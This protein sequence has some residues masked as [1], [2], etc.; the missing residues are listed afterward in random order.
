MTITSIYSQ[1]EL[2]LRV[3]ESLLRGLS[4]TP[5]GKLLAEHK[6]RVLEANLDTIELLGRVS[7]HARK[8][9]TLE[10]YSN[11]NRTIFKAIQ[12]S[13]ACQT[14]GMTLEDLEKLGFRI[15]N[16][17]EV[18]VYGAVILANIGTT[19]K[20]LL[21]S[22]KTSHSSVV[23]V[24]H[25]LV[26]SLDRT[27]VSK[28]NYVFVN[29]KKKTIEKTERHIK[30]YEYYQKVGQEPC[31]TL[32]V[33]RRNIKNTAQLILDN[34][35]F[36][37]DRFAQHKHN[38]HEVSLKTHVD[39]KGHS[40]SVCY[41]FLDKSGYAIGIRRRELLGKAEQNKELKEFKKNHDF[42]YSDEMNKT[43]NDLK[44]RI[45]DDKGKLGYHIVS[46]PISNSKAF[47]SISVTM[48]YLAGIIEAYEELNSELDRLKEDYKRCD[49]W[50]M[51]ELIETPIQYI[52][53][54]LY[55]LEESLNRLL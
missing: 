16:F 3:L 11:L 18:D 26:N 40:V 13:R 4:N 29:N 47:L 51:S 28:A 54:K 14:H 30:D 20:T 37:C 10:D 33:L 34:G 22:I 12:L 44:L 15:E 39:K 43:M 53:E 48:D 24:L 1:K 41:G 46:N 19:F 36:T 55:L 21:N 27:P 42:L 6:S 23:L 9:M 38:K 7:E 50:A 25:N 8:I 45:E 35:I 5:L 32:I 49:H 31:V 17:D 52:Q 2:N